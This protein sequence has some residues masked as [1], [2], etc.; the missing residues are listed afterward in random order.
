M[1]PTGIVEASVDALSLD[2]DN[3][4]LLA[5]AFTPDDQILTEYFPADSAPDAYSTYW[6]VPTPPDDLSVSHGDGGISQHQFF[7]AAGLC[8]I[9]HH[10]FG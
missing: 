7:A 6:V 8:C 3:T 1:Q 5:S 10:A 9:P 2:S 4:P